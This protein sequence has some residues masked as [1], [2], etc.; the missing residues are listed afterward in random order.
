MKNKKWIVLLSFFGLIIFFASG[1]SLWTVNEKSIT[2]DFTLD[3][4]QAVAYYGKGK[5]RK[6]FTSVEG[7]VT[8]A[9]SSSSNDIVYVIPGTNPTILSNCTIAANDTLCLPYSGEECYK[10]YTK[11]DEGDT[12][13]FADNDCKKYRKSRVTISSGCSITVNG[14]MIVGGLTGGASPQGATN[15]DYS[16]ILMEEN[17]SI[18]LESGS[19]LFCYGFIKEKDS[20]KNAMINVADEAKVY[21]PA[22]I[23]D[24][25]TATKV[26]VLSHHGK[27]DGA[28]NSEI[29]N[30]IFP[31]NR[32]DFPN[33]RP[34]LR[35]SYGSTLW[36]MVHTFG[37]N[38]G[39]LYT[40]AKILSKDSDSFVVRSPGA[41]IYWHF[42]DSNKEVDGNWPT[43][44]DGT[45]HKT[46]I[47]MTGEC[48]LGKLNVSL[49][50]NGYS[51]VVDSS[52]YFLPIPYLFEIVAGQG[53]SQASVV[54]PNRIK[55]LPGS[56]L[57]ILKGSS[58]KFDNDVVFYQKNRS[59][60][61][62]NPQPITYDY[63]NN[64]AATLNNGGTLIINK[65]FG[66]VINPTDESAILTIGQNYSRVQ[67]CYEGLY[68]GSG[69]IDT[70]KAIWTKLELD[71][72][73][74]GVKYGPYASTGGIVPL[75]R[76]IYS[77]NRNDNSITSKI[78]DMGKNEIL[79]GFTYLSEKTADNNY[80]WNLDYYSF[81]GVKFVLDPKNEFSDAEEI[82]NPNSENLHVDRIVNKSQVLEALSDPSG[83]KLFKG[84]SYD[85]LGTDR[86][87]GNG[88]TLNIDKVIN[89]LVNGIVT[90]Y[91]NWNDAEMPVA[92]V[93]TAYYEGN[94]LVTPDSY[95]S[96]DAGVAL[97]LGNLTSRDR[98]G[99]TD[100]DNFKVTYE[101]VDWLVK[102]E[103]DGT[104]THVDPEHSFVPQEKH[105]YTIEPIYKTHYFLRINV[106]N[107]K[108]EGFLGIGS[109]Y[110]I[111]EIIIQDKT[112]DLQHK[113]E[114][115]HT[116]WIESTDI[117]TIRIYDNK[118]AGCTIDIPGYQTITIGNGKTKEIKFTTDTDS[119][120]KP[121]LDA[122]MNR[123]GPITVNG[124]T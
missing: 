84:F 52:N 56:S 64:T 89:K 50:V 98:E 117:L 15:G 120:N 8:S 19:T 102:D 76:K 35:F 22:A 46:T 70:L 2:C 77:Y 20:A 104:E 119:N 107:K 114:K 83:K 118:N 79:S 45:T 96:V 108:H 97:S 99:G 43:K 3:V 71:G 48:K 110:A 92:K 86:L 113:D 11:T 40:N 94:D 101:N 75:V 109:W 95:S 25:A 112:N 88:F 100:K 57:T 51:I 60:S 115:T 58:V 23:Y 93:R 105:S 5:D 121:L 7:A 47:E 16:E 106:T 1:F 53:G 103:T 62:T 39:H 38:A 33:I 65:G 78:S 13:G 26:L 55:F 66:G 54:I 18:S 10:E 32:Y 63:S 29:Y 82:K 122:F 6:Y 4:K 24:W 91:A 30:D 31:F 49:T 17:T 41:V 61:L 67:D 44:N 28:I 85:S 59:D 90:V 34:T 87:D 21:E 123:T 37:T 36:G 73:G 14:T 111:Q 12:S 42:K 80:S 81:Y 74:E 116:G 72:K 68:R 27:I 124:T 69:A 9:E